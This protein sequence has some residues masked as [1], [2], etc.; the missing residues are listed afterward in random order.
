VIIV[1]LGVVVNVLNMEDLNFSNRA[2]LNK[3][4][5]HS[6]ATLV[7]NIEYEASDDWSYPF[8]GSWRISNC[9]RVLELS[10][11]LNT[12]K[13]LNNTIYKMEKIIEVTSSFKDALERIKPKVIEYELKRKEDKKKEKLK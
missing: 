10:I 7:V 3:D 8:Y 9:E 11:D 5:Y 1:I 4:G 13:D 12:I 6:N 2:F